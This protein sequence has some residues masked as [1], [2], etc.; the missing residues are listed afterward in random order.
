MQYKKI[1]L[2]LQPTY[3]WSYLFPLLVIF[4]LPLEDV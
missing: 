1:F 4:L 3:S 2:S